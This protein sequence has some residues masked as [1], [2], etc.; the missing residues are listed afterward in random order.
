MQDKHKHKHKP[1]SKAKSALLAAAIAGLVTTSLVSAG[2][3]AYV[4]HLSVKDAAL[5][6]LRLSKGL[7]AFLAT[8]GSSTV[9]GIVYGI[10]RSDWQASSRFRAGILGLSADLVAQ[11]G[12][13]WFLTN[14]LSRLQGLQPP[15]AGSPES[16]ALALGPCMRALDEARRYAYPSAEQSRASFDIYKAELLAALRAAAPAAAW[17][18][19]NADLSGALKAAGIT[20]VGDT[21]QVIEERDA[22]MKTCVEM[23]ASWPASFPFQEFYADPRLCDWQDYVGGVPSECKRRSP[24]PGDV[25]LRNEAPDPQASVQQ[26]IKEAVE[27]YLTVSKRQAVA[28]RWPAGKRLSSLSEQDVKRLIMNFKLEAHPDKNPDPQAA[29]NFRRIAPILNRHLTKLQGRS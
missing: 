13:A 23:L 15:R 3:I 18:R 7:K 4:K 8:R 20:F 17:A 11:Q 1:E 24:R 12:F 10:A 5:R 9:A 19:E 27:R 26:A 2:S 25:P 21:K 29:E 28:Q 16:A 22:D 6:D 14:A